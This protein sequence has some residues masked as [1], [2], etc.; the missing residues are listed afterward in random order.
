M[1]FYVFY[2]RGVLN[3]KGIVMGAGRDSLTHCKPGKAKLKVTLWDRTVSDMKED[4][5][6]GDRI[7]TEEL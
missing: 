2:T 6:E 7:G 4:D 5:S 1:L 3:S